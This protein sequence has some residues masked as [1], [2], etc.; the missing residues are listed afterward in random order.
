MAAQLLKVL[1]R[2]KWPEASLDDAQYCLR[3]FTS[4]RPV[5]CNALEDELGAGGV[6]AWS[7]TLEADGMG[8]KGGTQCDGVSWSSL[9]RHRLGRGRGKPIPP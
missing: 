4:C 6:R 9:Q 3:L 7:D 8:I 2:L 5:L 1:V